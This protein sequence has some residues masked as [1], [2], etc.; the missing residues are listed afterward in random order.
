MMARITACILLFFSVAIFAHAA[1][2]NDD[3]NVFLQM[4]TDVTAPTTPGSLTATPITTSQI[5]LSWIASTDDF[6]M[7]GYQ[8]FR[9]AVQIATTTL[10]TYSDTG[11]TASTA[12]AYY[13][14]AFDTS[15]NYSSSSNIAATSTYA[16]TPTSTPTTTD[17]VAS[18]SG[19][20]PMRL[21]A[22]S[23]T[24]EITSVHFAWQ[25]NNY[26]KFS[27]RWGRTNSYELGYVTNASFRREHTTSIADLEPNTVYYYQ[28]LAEDRNGK[29]IVL[30]EDKFTTLYDQDVTA[31]SNVTELS[32]VLQDD[33]TVALHWK[34]PTAEDFSHVRIVR[35]HLFYPSDV[36]DGFTL[37]VGDN[38]SFVDQLQM[39]HNSTRYYTVFSYDTSGNISS[40]AVVAITLGTQNQVPQKQ[41]STSA[42]YSTTI[43]D[44]VLYQ[45]QKEIPSVDGSF[46]VD[47]SQPFTIVLPYERA[48]RFVKAIIVTF[49]HPLNEA[50][51]YSF[52]LRLNK[53][54]TAYEAEISPL[55]FAGSAHMRFAIYDFDKNVLTEFSGE[56]IAQTYEDAVVQ[57]VSNAQNNNFLFYL[58]LLFVLGCLSL[59][60]FFFQRKLRKGA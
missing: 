52:L 59:L 56:I 33:N 17:P 58:F 54:G 26:A 53:A 57:F 43:D 18:G 25:T 5:N 20:A 14:V 24:P 8:V 9:D 29:I 21:E 12:Y 34:N 27:L 40:G 36:Y 6:A 48:P 37:Y 39:Q 2:T 35:N 23:V 45:K 16:I 31:P 41:A 28:L 15:Y 32:A 3:F 50:L 11:L 22:F 55:R 13:V 49:V 4:G 46:S 30:A 44:I 51:K 10:T 47:T 1:T 7:G 38:I 19:G 60:I 42:P